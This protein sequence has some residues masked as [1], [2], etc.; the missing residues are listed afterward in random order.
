MLKKSIRKNTSRLSCQVAMSTTRP[1][2]AQA[3]TQAKYPRL[4]SR[5]SSAE[6]PE[7]SRSSSLSTTKK[8]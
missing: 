3:Q 7:D 2:S 1:S 4:S 5:K 8:A 6:P